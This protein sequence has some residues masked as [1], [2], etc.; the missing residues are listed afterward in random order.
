MSEGLKGLAIDM[1]IVRVLKLNGNRWLLQV[2]ADSDVKQIYCIKYMLNCKVTIEKFE[3]KGLVQC[4]N[5]QRFG[6]ISSNCSMPYRC[7]KCSLSHGP[8]NCKIS[9]ENLEFSEIVENLATGQFFQ[10]SLIRVKCINCIKEGHVAS[11]RNCPVRI[12]L[13]KRLNDKK[14]NSRGGVL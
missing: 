8:G 12:Q 7:V 5:W 1:K 3:R 13:A 10:R 11:D 9:R 14:V 4:K 2:S 6:H